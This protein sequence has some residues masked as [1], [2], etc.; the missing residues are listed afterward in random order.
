[1]ID[2]EDRDF[3]EVELLQRG[4]QLGLEL[5]ARLAIDLA[6]LHVDDVLGE[7]AAM[8]VL[9]ADEQLL[10]ALIGEFLGEPRG[11]LAAGFDRAL[12]GR[13]VDQAAR[14][15]GAAPAIGT[16]RDAADFT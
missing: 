13:S 7:V 1:M 4:E 6:R 3:L 2:V 15:L 5:L 8:K 11:D 10:Q 9:V 14:R 12:A 16:E